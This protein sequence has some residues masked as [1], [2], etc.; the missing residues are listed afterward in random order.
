ME[1]LVYI[2]SIRMNSWVGAAGG[3]SDV[4]YAQTYGLSE[5]LEICRRQRDGEGNMQS[6]PV[7]VDIITSVRK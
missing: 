1:E 6:F 7:S 3:T 5:A 4:K 2:W